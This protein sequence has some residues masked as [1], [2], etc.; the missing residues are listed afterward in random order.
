MAVLVAIFISY[1]YSL[2]EIEHALF[3]VCLG[4]ILLFCKWTGKPLWGYQQGGWQAPRLTKTQ[5]YHH[6]KRAER[7]NKQNLCGISCVVFFY[8][9]TLAQHKIFWAR[10]V[11]QGGLAIEF[12]CQ[13]E[14]IELLM[15]RYHRYL[16][17]PD[18]I[19][20]LD[21]QFNF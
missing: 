9:Y 10:K 5:K 20:L 13:Y 6:R 14:A 8:R 7:S 2:T 3:M 12:C 11:Q 16:H 19:K 17:K 4:M 21:T 18:V 1:I 15:R